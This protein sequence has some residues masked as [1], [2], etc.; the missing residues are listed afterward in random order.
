L[1]EPLH[2]GRTFDQ[3]GDFV[4]NIGYVAAVDGSNPPKVQTTPLGRQFL[5]WMVINRV[6]EFKP[7]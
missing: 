1:N 7:G 4:A 2:K 6:S 5:E 3:W